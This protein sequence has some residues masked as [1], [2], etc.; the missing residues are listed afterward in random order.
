MKSYELIL[1]IWYFETHYIHIIYLKLSLSRELDIPNTICFGIKTILSFVLKT[2][3]SINNIMHHYDTVVVGLGPSGIAY[4]LE[5]AP[6]GERT[7]FL[8]ANAD[9]GGCWRSAFNR[10]GLYTEHSPKVMFKYGNRYTNNLI[11]HVGASLKFKNVYERGEKIRVL[12]VFFKNT[13]F[14]D[15]CRLVIYV[16]LYSLGRQDDRVSVLDWCRSAKL[17]PK[18]TKLISMLCILV[19]NTPD[20][21]R[22]AILISVLFDIGMWMSIDQLVDPR[23]WLRLSEMTLRGVPHYDIRYNTIVKCVQCDD[24]VA[25]SVVT[26]EDQRISAKRFV[27]CVPLRRLLRIVEESTSLLHTNWFRSLDVFRNY[28]ERSSYTGVGFQL[29]FERCPN[30]P[31]EWC[32]S[33]VGDW[34]VIVVEKS[35]SLEEFTKSPY[36]KAVW[37]CVVVDL[38]TKSD[39]LGRSANECESLDEILDESVRQ[40]T[41]AYGSSLDAHRRTTHSN[42]FRTKGRWEAWETSFS[43]CI[44]TL[45]HTGKVPNLH[46]IGP[47][48]IAS[49][50]TIESAIRSVV[51]FQEQR[52]NN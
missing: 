21:V 17:T 11:R 1:E 10:E 7:L 6:L 29:H 22:M 32:W 50:A 40:I 3:H 15:I 18:A 41:V 20:K 5:N 13:T 9:L 12:S 31:S 26:G 25:T 43:D 23:E 36:V 19:S 35:Y 27:F 2:I 37:S 8:E 39:A 42:I 28:V 24:G 44:G 4:G 14:R 46:S 47:H 52:R 49:I 33:C 51:L 30:F 38:E 48:N 45:P 34:N 16:V